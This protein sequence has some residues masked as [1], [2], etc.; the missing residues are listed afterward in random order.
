MIILNQTDSVPTATGTANRAVRRVLLAWRTRSRSRQI[1][2]TLRAMSGHQLR[3]IGLR[4][5]QIDQLSAGH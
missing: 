3:D 4:R 5:D 1:G 2:A